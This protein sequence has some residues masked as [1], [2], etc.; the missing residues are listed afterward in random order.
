MN[1]RKM[2]T[3]VLHLYPNI[4]FAK[5]EIDTKIKNRRGMDKVTKCVLELMKP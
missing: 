5:P 3:I 1:F 2:G 4:G